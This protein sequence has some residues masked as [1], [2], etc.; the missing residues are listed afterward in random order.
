M[1]TNNFKRELKYI[2]WNTEAYHE[3]ISQAE[4]RKIYDGLLAKG[5][6]L[7]ASKTKRL[8]FS[9]NTFFLEKV[10]GYRNIYLYDSD[11]KYKVFFANELDDD[12][13]GN[14]RVTGCGAVH[15]FFEKFNEINGCKQKGFNGF[16]GSATEDV[17]NCV[18]KGFYFKNLAFKDRIIKNVSAVD[19]CSH[20]SSSAMGALPDANTSIRLSGI[21]SPTAEYPYAFYPLSGDCA[22]YKKFNTKFWHFSDFEPFLFDDKKK[23]KGKEYTI[24]MKKSVKTLDRTFSWFYNSR[25]ENDSYKTVMNA[26]IGM[27]HTKNYTSYHYAHIAAIAIARANKKM[28][29]LAERIGIQNILQICVDGIIYKG[30]E[31]YGGTEK[32]LGKLFQEYTGETIKI[33]GMNCYIVKDKDGNVIKVKHGAYNANEDGSLIEESKVKDFSDMDGWKRLDPLAGW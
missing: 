1:L 19:F 33:R 25:K 13:N 21:K 32:G 9:E 16:F 4:M 14:K 29:D 17:K 23:K 15:L 6:Q 28:L 31:E 30:K 24:L 7:T 27:F 26:T 3:K 18:P 2:N 22:E 20:Y 12:K 11:G 5:A 10:N 8:D